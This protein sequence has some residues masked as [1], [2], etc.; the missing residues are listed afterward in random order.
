MAMEAMSRVPKP[1]IDRQHA[2]PPPNA[3]SAATTRSMTPAAA[4]FQAVRTPTPRMPAVTR[5]TE[6]AERRMRRPGEPA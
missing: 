4:S 6:A 3:T 2:P 1:P 5:G